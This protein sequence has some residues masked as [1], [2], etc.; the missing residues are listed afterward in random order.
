MPQL[1]RNLS[2][3][4]K[5]LVTLVLL[6]FL[7]YEVHWTEFL[8]TL[9]RV[10]I[11][12]LII[13]SL[14]V[15]A[16]EAVIA[17]RL[18]VLLSP[19]CFDLSVFKL[20]KIGFIA[21]FYAFFL[22]SGLGLGIAR[23]F[24]IT[25]NKRGRLIFAFVTFIEKSLFFAVCILS[26]TVP[27][28]V[29]SDNQTAGLREALLPVLLISLV[30]MAILFTSVLFPLVNR[31]VGEWLEAIKNRIKYRLDFLAEI[32][33][34]SSLYSGRLDKMGEAGILTLLIQ[35]AILTRIIMLFYAVGAN[36]PIATAL[37]IASLVFLIQALP[38]SFAGL[39]VRESA[40]A[41]A[42]GLYGLRPE[43]GAAVGVLFL[44]QLIMCA[45]I[46]GILRVIAK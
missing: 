26:I 23:W 8:A 25:G 38:I 3:L 17:L 21:W 14:I 27:L 18:K 36:L 33:Q 1:R 15:L 2:L 9:R 28:I 34:V 30:A 22:P 40:F 35:F 29:I 43:S 41:Y 13:S 4:F 44:G 39:G 6:V 12:W 31:K 32:K 19:T 10:D 37:W 42:F 20:L 46:G 11:G 16:G 7:L 24:L 5:T 45:V